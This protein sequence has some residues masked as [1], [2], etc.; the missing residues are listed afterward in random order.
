MVNEKKMIKN[1]R[2]KICSIFC[3]LFLHSFSIIWEKSGIE[4]FP[5]VM[6]HETDT[7]QSR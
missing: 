3:L 2:T 1:I 7:Y 4:L 5:G 6:E